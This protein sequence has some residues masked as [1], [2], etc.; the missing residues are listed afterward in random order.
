MVIKEEKEEIIISLEVKGI[1]MI[2]EKEKNMDLKKNLMIK[3]MTS[4]ILIGIITMIIGILNK[5]KM[6]MIDGVTVKEKMN[7]VIAKKKMNGV[8][9]KIIMIMIIGM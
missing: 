1:E 5:R 4:I 7:G 2:K 6:I 9:A 3:E 8:I